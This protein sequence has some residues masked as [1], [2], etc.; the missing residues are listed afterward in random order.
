[1]Q[2]IIPQGDPEHQCIS[3]HGSE[4]YIYMAMLSV[5]THQVPHRESTKVRLYIE[6]RKL[7]PHDKQGA[8]LHIKILVETEVHVNMFI[9]TEYRLSCYV[10]IVFSL[11]TQ[12]RVW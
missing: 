9:D 2:I 8:N 10:I 4:L 11:R 5:H 3:I 6:G 12:K 7:N 1:M